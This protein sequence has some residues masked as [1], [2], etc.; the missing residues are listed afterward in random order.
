MAKLPSNLVKKPL[1]DNP[2]RPTEERKLSVV[3]AELEAVS[4]DPAPGEVDAVETLSR[5]S[6][7][8][9]AEREGEGALVHRVTVRFTDE[10]WKALQ[11]VCHERRL[12]GEH[13]S[14]AEL[15]RKIVN[16]WHVRRISA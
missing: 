3:N 7:E 12:R 8:A 10:Q 9:A 6:V 16:D 1:F 15:V 11:T 5:P 4:V 13:V 14:V 2:M